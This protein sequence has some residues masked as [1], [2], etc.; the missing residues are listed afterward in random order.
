MKVLLSSK[1]HYGSFQLVVPPALFLSHQMNTLLKEKIN[2]TLG[3]SIVPSS[4]KIVSNQC[5]HCCAKQM[6]LLDVVC[7]EYPMH[8][9]LWSCITSRRLAC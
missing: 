1:L 8:I 4:I 7:A 3:T 9:G 6:V 5:C 2:V